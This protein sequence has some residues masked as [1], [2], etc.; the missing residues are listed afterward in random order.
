MAAA[1]EWTST[2]RCVIDGVVFQTYPDGLLEMDKPHIEMS[3]ADFLL[4]KERPVVEHEARLLQDLRPRNVFELGI[5]WGGSTAF[6]LEAAQPEQLV[7][8]DLHDGGWPELRSHIAKRG[9]EER[10]HLYGGVDQADRARL[11]E[12]SEEAFG[13][14]PID[15]V[16]DDCSHMYEESRRSFNELFPRLRAD[17]LYVIEDWPWAHAT[18]GSENTEGMWPEKTP[19]TKLVFELILAVPSMRDLIAEIVI[20]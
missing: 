4:L 9:A 11:A 7:A 13:G 10:V 5:L 2:E 16:V 6:L 19:L 1:V 8:I 14:E 20:D 17:G 12:I 18:I 3:G 15:L